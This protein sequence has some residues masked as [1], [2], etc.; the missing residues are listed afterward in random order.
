MTNIK[1]S[2]PKDADSHASVTH[3]LLLCRASLYVCRETDSNESRDCFSKVRHRRRRRPIKMGHPLL[4]RRNKSK[5]VSRALEPL[6]A[7]TRV[8]VRSDSNNQNS[9]HTQL[10][11]LPDKGFTCLDIRADE[12]GA[13]IASTQI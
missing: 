5:H 7:S 1:N 12:S 11:L 4:L 13:P 9:A 6:F 10:T 2:R 8:K 3:F